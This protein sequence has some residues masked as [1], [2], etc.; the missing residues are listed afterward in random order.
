MQTAHHTNGTVSPFALLT[1]VFCDTHDEIFN[2]KVQNVSTRTT[3]SKDSDS[4]SE[5]LILSKS[6]NTLHNL[7]EKTWDVILSS[8]RVST[9]KTVGP[10]DMEDDDNADALGQSGSMRAKPQPRKPDTKS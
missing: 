8:G 9:C 2:R 7:F 4:A 6:S 10:E 3:K 1:T 5:T